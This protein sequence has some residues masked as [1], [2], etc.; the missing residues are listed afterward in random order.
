MVI[1]DWAALI[2]G[3]LQNLW[4]GVIATIG[5]IIGALV[6]LLIGLL[7]ASGLAALV[8]R[9]VAMI[10]LD[11]VLA[12]LGIEEYFERA[13]LKLNSAL[14]FGRIVYWFFVVVFLL[15][16][17]D[18]LKFYSLS[19]FLS[20]V[21][22]YVPNVI[23]GVLIMLAAVVVANFLR[24][25]VWASVKSARLHS[26]GFLGSLTWWAVIL[27]G[28]FAALTQLGVAV[29]LINSLVTGFVAMLAIA[30]GIAFGLGGKD[31]ASS[32]INKLR[33]HTER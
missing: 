15:A 17:T 3:S 6:V 29:S 33:E 27:F 9:I 20:D 31:Y 23:V 7:V 18:I 5:D 16:A 12:K 28:F 19:N 21:L 13:G 25:L 24:K 1:Q 14:F 26:A 22:L 2:V 11:S 4:I 32:L 10:K 30:G 8:E